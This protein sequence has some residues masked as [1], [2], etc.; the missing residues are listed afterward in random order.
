MSDLYINFVYEANNTAITANG[1]TYTP[2]F[3][4]SDTVVVIGNVSARDLT[5][6]DVTATVCK[7]LPDG[8]SGACLTK[9]VGDGIQLFTVST[10]ERRIVITLFPSAGNALD[11]P[12]QRYVFDI[13]LVRDKEFGVGTTV[14]DAI[15][16]RQTIKGQFVITEDY[17]LN[18]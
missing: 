14:G 1:G 8:S 5:N 13:E 10:N 17:T 2:E 6:F 15:E 16:M 12:G 4:R 18:A 9:I 11:E 3:V 7:V